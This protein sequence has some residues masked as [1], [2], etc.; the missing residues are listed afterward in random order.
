MV[1]LLTLRVDQ[2]WLGIESY[3]QWPRPFHALHSEGNRPGLSAGRGL[4]ALKSPINY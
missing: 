3:A 1:P 4:T 2:N